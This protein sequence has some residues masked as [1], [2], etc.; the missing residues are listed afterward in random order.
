MSKNK[1][2]Q[3]LFCTG[4]DSE[5]KL[6]FNNEDVSSY[7]KFC[8]FCA[9]ELPVDDEDDNFDFQDFDFDEE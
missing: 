4:C 2:N 8:P 6:I 3:K 1:S 5:F 9:D 7:P